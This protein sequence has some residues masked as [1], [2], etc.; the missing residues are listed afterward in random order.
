MGMVIIV[1][2][3]LIYFASALAVKKGKIKHPDDYF[4]AY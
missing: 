2:P 4:I 1:I 3:L